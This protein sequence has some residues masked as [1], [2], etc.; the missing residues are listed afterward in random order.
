MDFTKIDFSKFDVTKM[1]DVQ[2]ALDNI[3]SSSRTALGYIPDAKSRGIAQDVMAAH[4]KFA[5]AQAEAMQDF[6]NA[7]K[8][9]VQSK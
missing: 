7:V 2:A 1:F 3:E 5:R 9:A 8:S 6:A 4:M